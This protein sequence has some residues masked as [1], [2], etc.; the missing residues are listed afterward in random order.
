MRLGWVLHNP[1]DA[2]R[3]ATPILRAASATEGMLCA[4][5]A[6]LSKAEVSES[7]ACC[8]GA[9]YSERCLTPLPGLAALGPALAPLR[10]LAAR[11]ARP[12]PAHCPGAPAHGSRAV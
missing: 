6:A 1:R 7:S 3:S 4:G 10:A 2:R 11:L 9:L 8:D 12:L 5:F